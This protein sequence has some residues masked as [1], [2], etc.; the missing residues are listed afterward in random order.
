MWKKYHFRDKHG[1]WYM[2]SSWDGWE[3]LFYCSDTPMYIIVAGM[4]NINNPELS[5]EEATQQ[6][7]Y[8]RLML[9]PLK[10]NEPLARYVKLRVAHAPGI[11]RTFSPPPIS[12]ESA[13]Q[14]S[15]HASRYVRHARAVMHAGVANPWWRGKHSRHTR[16]M[17][18]PQFHV[19]GKR[20]MVRSI[21]LTVNY[22]LW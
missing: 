18:N 20:P 3:V 2:K 4:V 12:K 1:D 17:R 9:C 13:R 21:R 15:R 6:L 10:V 7:V 19:F 22:A 5:M 14:R 16:R 8:A 11:P